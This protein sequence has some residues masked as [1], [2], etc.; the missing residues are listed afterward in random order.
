MALGKPVVVNGKCD[1][2]RGHCERSGGG[3]W[4]EEYGSFAGAMEELMGEQHGMYGKKAK[5]YVDRFYRWDKVLEKWH[6]IWKL[7]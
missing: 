6:K 3:L 5:E 7:V 2:L 1:V 4:Y